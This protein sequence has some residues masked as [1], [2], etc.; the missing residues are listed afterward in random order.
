MADIKAKIRTRAYVKLVGLDNDK[1]DQITAR[2]RHVAQGY[3]FYSADNKLEQGAMDAT[4]GKTITPSD[5]QVII[6]G[7]KYLNGDIIVEPV[8]TEEK[9]VTPTESEQVVTPSERKYLKQVTVGAVPNNYV[10]SGVPIAGGETITP[11]DEQVIIYGEKYLN[12]DIIVEPVPTEEKSVTPTESEQVVTPSER[13]YLKQ[14]TVGAVPNNYV[15]SNIQRQ[16]EVTLIPSQADQVIAKNQYLIGNVTVKGDENLKPENISK[17]VIIYKGTNGEIIGTFKGGATIPTVTNIKVSE[18]GTLTFDEVDNTGLE[19]YEPSFSYLIN[20]N[21]TK[22]ECLSSGINILSYLK[23]GENTISIVVKALLKQ[24]GGNKEEVIDYVIPIFTDPSLFTLTNT[25]ING[26]SGYKITAYNGSGT[27][28]TIPL[29][30]SDGLP[31]L[32]CV[33]LPLTKISGGSIKKIGSFKSNSIIKEISFPST[34]ENTDMGNY[35][36]GCTKLETIHALDTSNVTNM[37]SM[38]LYNYQLK[39]VPLFDTSKVTNMNSMFVYCQ[40]LKTVP[41]FDTSK[42]TNIDSMFTGCSS[43]ETVPLFDTSKVTSAQAVFAEC[44][45][46]TTIPALNVSNVNVFQNIFSKCTSLKSI[47]M[48]GMKVTFDISASTQFEREDLITILDNLATVTNTQTLT[49]GS[50]NL[51]KLTDADKAIATNKGWTLA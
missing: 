22:I 50:T 16:E 7:E 3:T 25:T 21:G 20:V 51:A 37:Q 10:G 43:L 24:N 30:N 18:Y 1:L 48:Y 49:M 28:I 17:G 2:A 34:V 36:N 5:E 14:V 19:E 31:I 44:G 35:F 15:G 8:P 42:V 47:L 40:K 13:K 23:D 9:S 26:E 41:L 39:T 12:G 46:L 45:M 4:N 32:E 29:T 38:F 11:S 6:Y 27:E 33:S